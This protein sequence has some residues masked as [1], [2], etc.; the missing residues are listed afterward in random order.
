MA[1]VVRTRQVATEPVTIKSRLELVAVIHEPEPTTERQEPPP[2][3]A[4]DEALTI[5]ERDLVV[6]LLNQPVPPPL[7]RRAI[8]RKLGATGPAKAQ[9]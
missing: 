6:Q 9:K 8:L 4:A 7:M 5:P 2:V 1:V 3:G